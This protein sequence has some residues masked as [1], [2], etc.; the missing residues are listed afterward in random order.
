MERGQQRPVEN[1][2]EDGGVEYDDYKSGPAGRSG[3]GPLP[4]AHAPGGVQ[5]C[6]QVS[7]RR[8]A[9]GGVTARIAFLTRLVMGPPECASLP[10]KWDCRAI[11]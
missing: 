7:C 1:G 9:A 4:M 11:L 6:S 10:T 8:S 5:D 3:L 2:D